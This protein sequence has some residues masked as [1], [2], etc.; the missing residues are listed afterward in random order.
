MDGIATKCLFSRRTLGRITLAFQNSK[1][2][3]IS[4]ENLNNMDF[5]SQELTKKKFDG[6]GFVPSYF[7]ALMKMVIFSHFS[8]YSAKGYNGY[9]PAFYF[10]GFIV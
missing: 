5:R 3:K 10:E 7:P 4:L 9:N 2:I 6:S 8:Q 1:V